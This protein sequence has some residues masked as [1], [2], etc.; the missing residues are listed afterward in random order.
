[1]EARGHE[2]LRLAISGWSPLAR[3]YS[4]RRVPP[5]LS[6]RQGPIRLGSPAF[7]WP[8][9]SANHGRMAAGPPS[10]RH[11]FRAIVLLFAILFSG[12]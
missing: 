8:Q 11:L 4:C 5:F 7:S 12:W 9:S 3:T 2:C 6:C 1:M 10:R